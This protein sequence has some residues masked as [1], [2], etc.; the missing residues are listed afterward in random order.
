MGFDMR[1]SFYKEIP[2]ETWSPPKG[3]VVAFYNRN[4]EA[5]LYQ[6]TTKLWP[7]Q[8]QASSS[9]P[10]DAGS[11]SSQYATPSA[12][13][14]SAQNTSSSSAASAHAQSGQSSQQA[15]E[16]TVKIGKYT[17]SK[18]SRHL[19]SPSFR[20]WLPLMKDDEGK[21]RV[22]VGNKAYRML[23]EGDNLVYVDDRSKTHVL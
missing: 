20:Q 1:R 6:E 21:Q 19:W 13:T 4:G 9:R 22:Q 17:F 2:P 3:E 5:E 8:A 7:Q 15:S 11:T 16:S 10:N 18:D 14:T 12:S 23:K